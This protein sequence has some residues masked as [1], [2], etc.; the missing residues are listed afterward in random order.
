MLPSV[1]PNPNPTHPPPH[2]PSLLQNAVV[3][4]LLVSSCVE[5]SEGEEGRGLW[6]VRVSA[7]APPQPAP[8][9]SVVAPA[10]RS[11]LAAAA[12]ETAA[13]SAP[14]PVAVPLTSILKSLSIGCDGDGAEGGLFEV[15]VR[16]RAA[17]L[18]PALRF[19][20][21]CAL[22]CPRV[23]PP[24]PLHFLVDAPCTHALLRGHGAPAVV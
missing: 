5:A 2:S 10:L 20:S 11:P 19:E 9:Q 17:G 4:T 18:A 14:A 3:A 7:Q 24:P 8:T 12:A 21:E 13:S 15:R 16:C 6:R 1:S 23:S 22:T